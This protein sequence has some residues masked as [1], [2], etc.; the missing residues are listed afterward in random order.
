MINCRYR[1]DAV[2][3][4]KQTVS[5]DGYSGIVRDETRVVE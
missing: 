1:H 2:F 5:M 3:G 4:R